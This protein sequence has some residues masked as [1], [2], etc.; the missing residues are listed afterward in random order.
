VLDELVEDELL[1]E[2]EDELLD[3]ELLDELAAPD[4]LLLDD[5]SAWLPTPGIPPQPTKP[6]N[7][8][9]PPTSHRLTFMKTSLLWRKVWTPA[10]QARCHLC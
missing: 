8:P 1:L 3:E 10:L 2:E 4:E 9:T 7:A 6:R 5:D